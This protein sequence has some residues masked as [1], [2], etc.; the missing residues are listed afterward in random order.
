M[1]CN[2]LTLFLCVWPATGHS[3]RIRAGKL[4]LGKTETHTRSYLE[5]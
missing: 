2:K 1:F 3:S 4:S 5:Y